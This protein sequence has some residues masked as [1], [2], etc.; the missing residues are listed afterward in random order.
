MLASV[1]S[2]TVS[3]YPPSTSLPEWAV[4]YCRRPDCRPARWRLPLAMLLA[5][6]MASSGS[7]QP[8]VAL[9]AKEDQRVAIGPRGN[10][11]D[12][13]DDDE[14]VAPFQHLLDRPLEH[15]QR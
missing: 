15:G 14:N 9:A 2:C 12:L 10:R 13:A 5:V 6:R 3:W 8:S 11:D 1:I 7:T 4:P